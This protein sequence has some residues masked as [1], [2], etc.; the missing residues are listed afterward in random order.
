MYNVSILLKHVVSYEVRFEASGKLRS[1]AKSAIL[2]GSLFKFRN[3]NSNTWRLILENPRGFDS[4]LKKKRKKALNCIK[5]KDVAR[6]LEKR[7]KR[8][9][10][11][12]QIQDLKNLVFG[13]LVGQGTRSCRRFSYLQCHRNRI[14]AGRVVGGS[15]IFRY[16]DWGIDFS[17]PAS[18]RV[19]E[20]A[21]KYRLSLSTGALKCLATS[22]S[23]NALSPEGTDYFTRVDSHSRFH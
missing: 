12:E 6:R 23:S 20:G 15:R 7:R 16:D 1:I 10:I 4:S 19:L 3:L 21:C 2:T 8:L 22:A 9:A 17:L 18:F 11:L 13:T 5:C 14:K